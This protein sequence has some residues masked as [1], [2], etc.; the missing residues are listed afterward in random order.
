MFYIIKAFKNRYAR[1]TKIEA[2][3]I[4]YKLFKF[5]TILEL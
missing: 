5:T 2:L 3:E 4:A 1:V